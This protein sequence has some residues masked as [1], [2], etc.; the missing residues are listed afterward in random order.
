MRCSLR[1]TSS[2]A[3]VLYLV[4]LAVSFASGVN[5]QW[6]EVA[7]DPAAYAARLVAAAGPLRVLLAVDDLF[8]VAYVI[9]TLALAARLAPGP[10]RPLVVGLVLAA[11]ALDLVENH[12][13]LALLAAPT[14]S[15]GELALQMI[16]SSTKWLLAHAAFVVIGLSITP[17][18]PIDRGFVAAAVFVQLPLGVLVWTHPAPPLEVARAISLASGFLYLA[19]RG[20]A[21]AGATGAPA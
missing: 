19:W 7:R 16:A 17:R 12:H 8:I 14:P 2:L 1:V 10:G 21:V 5:Q 13:L 15:A 4:L 3:L 20:D 6:F 18:A 9:A 11:G